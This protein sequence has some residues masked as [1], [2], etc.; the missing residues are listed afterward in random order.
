MGTFCICWE[1][2]SGSE[3]MGIGIVVVPRGR[4][5]VRDMDIEEI[6]EVVEK[7]E[8][9]NITYAMGGVEAR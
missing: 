5:V 8:S 7:E 9:I 1:K 6:G 3:S 2:A 4:E